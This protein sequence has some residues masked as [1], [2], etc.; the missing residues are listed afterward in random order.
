MEIIMKRLTPLIFA[1]IFITPCKS[2]D[3]YIDF[4]ASGTAGGSFSVEV[5]NLYNGTT[6]TMNGND[7][8]HLSATSDLP[9]PGEM[10]ENFRVWPNPY[11][12]C[13]H[14]SFV[15]PVDGSVSL[16][17]FDLAG[18]CLLRN[19]FILTQGEHWFMLNNLP[20]GMVFISINTP[21]WQAVRQLTGT[22]IAHQ[23]PVFRY[24]CKG[25]PARQ[26]S[27]NQ[28]SRNTVLLH[29]N[30]GE[31]LLLKGT[32]GNYGRI[33]TLKVTQNQTVDFEFIPCIDADL[34]HY[35]VVTIGSQTW[36]ACN[37]KST[38]YQNGQ[39]IPQVSDSA[40]WVYRITPGYC[41]YNNDALTF[42]D[43]YG[44]LYNFYVISTDSICPL[45]W[46]IPTQTEWGTL[47]SYLGGA[48]VAGG[49]L[50][51][52]GFTHWIQPNTGASNASGFTALPA[53]Y[54]SFLGKYCNSGNDGIWWSST[55]DSF[56]YAWERSVNFEGAHIASIL[57][58]KSNGYSVRC[59]KD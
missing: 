57:S 36:M 11:D 14:F 39:T 48:S 43:L 56:F 17:L 24:Q 46:H 8:L 37:L 28:D 5:Q 3:Y 44:A 2:Q 30:P 29:Y 47:Q 49:K 41:W 51:E 32:S 9:F 10:E 31:I 33:I 7:T 59:I 18:K 25:N 23:N 12:E 53:G 27:G 4:T 38:K 21:K 42:Q 15:Q 22:G 1:L 45:G 6:L 40:N 34:N 13:C 26:K 19:T 16:A 50:K 20:A 54:R 58:H 35:P 52:T 55:E